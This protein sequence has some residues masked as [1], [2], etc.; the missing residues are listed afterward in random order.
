MR[1]GERE[2]VG[3]EREIECE[4]VQ[5]GMQYIIKMGERGR[6]RRMPCDEESEGCRVARMERHEQI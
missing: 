5:E 2:G 3:R 6:M 4:M 1:G